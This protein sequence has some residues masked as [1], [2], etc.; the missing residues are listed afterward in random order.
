M[1][2]MKNFFLQIVNKSQ[3]EILKYKQA[4][5]QQRERRKA[6]EVKLNEKSAE[7]EKFQERNFADTQKLSKLFN[8][9]EKSY[10]QKMAAQAERIKM[11]EQ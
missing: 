6:G 3:G 9:K 11:L 4:Y 8:E 2:L 1:S 5:E 10:N 7:L